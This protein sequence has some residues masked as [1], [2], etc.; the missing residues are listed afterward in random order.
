M[1][2]PRAHRPGRMPEFQQ[3]LVNQF[4]DRPQ[5]MIRRDARLQTYIAEK[6]F[7]S[8]VVAARRI[9]PTEGIKHMHEIILQAPRKTTFSA[10]C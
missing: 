9:L 6:A 3:R 4:A 10:A 7:R 1:V 5:G 2:A 8:L